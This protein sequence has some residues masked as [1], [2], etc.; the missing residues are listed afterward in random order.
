MYSNVCTS[1]DEYGRYMRVFVQE[2]DE[3]DGI[4]HVRRLADRSFDDEFGGTIQNDLALLQIAIVCIVVYTYLAISNPRDGI[5]GSRLMLTFGGVPPITC[6][7]S[8]P[9]LAFILSLPTRTS[10]LRGETLAFQN[11]NACVQLA[12]TV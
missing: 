6:A 11:I 4:W 9:R 12:L 3:A 5:V 1:I 2:Q 10:V 8:L 7:C